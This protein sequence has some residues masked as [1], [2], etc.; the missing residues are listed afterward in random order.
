MQALDSINQCFGRDRAVV[1]AVGLKRA[2]T[3]K[4]DMRSPRYTTRELA[5]VVWTGFREG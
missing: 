1:G 3:T 4:F 5:P 2:W